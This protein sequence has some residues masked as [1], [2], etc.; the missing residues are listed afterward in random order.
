MDFN[1]EH[2]EYNSTTLKHLHRAKHVALSL[3]PISRLTNRPN[4]LLRPL[5]YIAQLTTSLAERRWITERA[6]KQ[7]LA[8]FSTHIFL[9]LL[10]KLKYSICSCRFN[11]W[12]INHM[13]SF[14]LNLFLYVWNI[15][16]CSRNMDIVLSSY[17]KSV[18]KS[19]KHCVF[20]TLVSE[21]SLQALF[22]NGHLA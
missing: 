4:K 12:N 14:I 6:I 3:L 7:G 1:L 18:R 11:I 10:T 13:F 5:P 22:L 15:I 16:V 17:V 9:G 8:F 19:R 21:P 20:S 2:I